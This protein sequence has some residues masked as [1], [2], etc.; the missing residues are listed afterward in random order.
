MPIS[1][2]NR[3]SIAHA[4]PHPTPQVTS[5]I[6]SPNYMSALSYFNKSMIDKAIPCAFLIDP[7]RSYETIPPIMTGTPQPTLTTGPSPPSAQQQ[8]GTI[9]MPPKIYRPQLPSTY[10]EPDLAPDVLDGMELLYKDHGASLQ[11]RKQPLSP[12]DPSNII[13]V[14]P[15]IHQQELDNNLN[16]GDCQQNIAQKSLPSSKN[17][18]MYSVK[19]A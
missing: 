5:S 6:V 1:T 14:D 9:Q 13:Y 11:K 12:Q 18:G 3:P 15:K 10:V 7:G 4:T 17:T 19:I 8:Q 2:P 16:W